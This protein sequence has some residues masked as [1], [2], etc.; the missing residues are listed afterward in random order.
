M[1]F[2]DEHLQCSNLIVLIIFAFMSFNFHV[3][4]N[5]DSQ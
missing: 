2:I 1:I 3:T 4:I 5:L